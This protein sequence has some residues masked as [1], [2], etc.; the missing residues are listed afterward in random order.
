MIDPHVAIEDLDPDGFALLNAIAAERL[1]RRTRELHVLHRSGVVVRSVRT[2]GGPVDVSTADPHAIRTEHDVDRVIC[3]D[4]DRAGDLAGALA[5][6]ALGTATQPDAIVASTRAFWTHP[7]VTTS[8]DPPG[9]A[10]WYDEL[11][12][13]L[14]SIP[15]GGWIALHLTDIDLRV[16]LQVTG[17]RII[18]ITSQPA[19]QPAQTLEL[20]TTELLDPATWPQR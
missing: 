18:R 14:V 19:T 15:D 12:A 16:A 2:D 17:G 3:V 8:P 9:P 5:E 6:A 7:A 11:A 1:Y 13:R 4:V 10:R 20:T